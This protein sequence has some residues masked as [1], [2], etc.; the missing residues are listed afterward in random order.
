MSF[1]SFV[2]TRVFLC[3]T[4]HADRFLVEEGKQGSPKMMTVG[5]HC[6]IVGRPGRA[7]GLAEFMDY[8]KSFKKDVWI[9]TR[10]EIAKHWYES[11]YPVG[12]GSP[13]KEDKKEVTAEDES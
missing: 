3:L 2:V 4:C 10:E 8:A 7:A 12:M 11:H 9:C 1:Y 13:I 6:R 5:L